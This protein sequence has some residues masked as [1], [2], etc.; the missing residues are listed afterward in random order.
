MSEALNRRGFLKISAALAAVPV[1]SELTGTYLFAQEAPNLIQNGEVVTGT[2]WG[3]L[4]VTLK[5]G[6]VVKSEAL[7]SASKI[8]N[9]LQENTADMI[10]KSRVKYP[11][12]RK[13]YLAD[14]DNPKPALR[15]SEEFVR[16]SYEDAIKL[17]ARELKKTRQEKGIDSVFAGS[18]G[19]KSVGNV[20]NS[21]ILLHRFMNL[22]GG[23][24]GSLGDYSTGASQVIMPHV[25]GSISVYEQQTS[26][27]VIL[28]DSDIVVL[29]GANPISTLRI[30]WQVDDG[31]AF[32]YLEKLKNSG[33][34][35]IIIDPRRSAT[36]KYFDKA[37]WIAPRPN[38]DTAIMLGMIYH[39]LSTNN[40][41]KDFLENYTVGFEKFTPYVLGKVDGVE[42][43]P[44]WAAKISGVKESVIKDL[45]KRFFDNRTMLMSGWS[46]QRA[47][48]GEQPHWMLVTLASMLG[49]IG[50]PGGGFS[51]GHHYSGAGV[52]S[53]KGG[54]VGGMNA[55]SVGHFDANGKFLGTGEKTASAGETGASWK[56]KVSASSFPVARIAD[57]LMNPGKKIQ[58]NGR[59]L[60]YPDIDFIY[61][62]GGNPFAH[63]QD[64]NTLV[65]AWKKPRTVVVNSIYW[66]PTA[67]MADIVF[68]TT[69]Q[70]ER[71]DIAMIGDY[72]NHGISPMKQLVQKQFEAKDDY[73]IFSDLCLAYEGKGLYNA[74]TDGG[75]DEMQW[76]EEYYNSAYNA[77]KA[78]PDLVTDMK[79]FAEFWANNKPVIFDSTMESE[80]FVKF[81]SFRDDPILEPLGTPS[82]LIEIYSKTIEKMKYDDCF[83]YPRWFEPIEWLGM[84]NKPA[85]FHM[86][87]PHPHD[88]LHS[89]QN[90]TSLR[91]RYAVGNHEPIWINPKDAAKKGIKNGD[92][93]R[94]FNARGE[95]LAGAV[96]TDD[97]IEG[98]VCLEE[99][100]WY[101]P[102]KPG[103]VGAI[104][105]NG[106]P[107][108]LT[109]DIPSSQLAN[110]NIS[111]TALVNIEKFSGKKEPL[112]AFSAPKGA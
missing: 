56:L 59:E 102:S 49:Q 46:L 40:Y 31:Q 27:P 78:N 79:P 33:K 2:H 112:T 34:K 107:N 52:P 99:G 18:Y 108:M 84:E 62:V 71:N 57:A 82:G 15:G 23:F 96:V 37:E 85:Q 60:T 111:H 17:V 41:D 92:T 10:Y 90:Q 80:A 6:K 93:V 88:R 74:Y 47:H 42:K 13:S 73:Q 29:W 72:S 1:V 69:S 64:T 55:A 30:S 68:P 19:W 4:K 106:S 77:V 110:G 39:L 95:A 20:H 53:R 86:I 100:V 58:H 75:K 24:T 14:P 36:V 8:P 32:G 48:Y 22:S 103:I 50:L 38:T 54:V 5:N 76:I 83:P 7:S 35:V 66:T 11:M 51:L 101:D 94:V 81:K 44:A 70:Y 104:C 63:H 9:A 26:W 98:V 28:E 25:V 43:T 61:W 12:V 97:I 3:V 21:R 105:K 45:A 65:K 67:K 91:D 87:S 89:Q 109:I 16:V